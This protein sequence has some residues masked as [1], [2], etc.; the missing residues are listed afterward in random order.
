MKIKNGYRVI[1]FS[2]NRQMVAASSTAS[3]RHNTIH[4]LLE[5]DVTK[6]RSL[7]AKYKESTGKSVSF[8]AYLVSCLSRVMESYP[9]FNSFRKGNNLIILEDLTISVLVERD[10]AGELVP[11]PLGIQYAQTKSIR[12]IQKEIR[13]AKG[14]STDELGSLSGLTWVRYIP[15][16]LLGLF[17]RAA[18]RNI[19]MAKRY[20]K[21][22]VTAVGM[23]SPARSWMVPISSAT[24]VMTVGGI[25]TELIPS[26]SQPQE[27]EFLHLTLSFD[28]DV[29]DGAPAARFAKDL[30]GLIA[31][32]DTIMEILEDRD[33]E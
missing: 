14:N 12:Q 4:C 28:H 24:V 20:G 27:A 3:R 13:A 15:T 23:F 2:A 1:P 19:N 8:T 10:L 26:D 22:A 29:V 16:W 18:S 33:H 31:A 17:I 25:H 21:V 5:V 30:E 6:P 32:G 7:L 11:E 9:D